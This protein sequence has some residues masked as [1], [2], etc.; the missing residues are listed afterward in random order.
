M[1]KVAVIYSKE[2]SRLDYTTRS[3]Q[4]RIRLHHYLK[5]NKMSFVES[6][7]FLQIELVVLI[8]IEG[9]QKWKNKL[10]SFDLHYFIYHISYVLRTEICSVY[11]I[12]IFQ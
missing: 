8:S 4:W 11:F 9:A 10:P 2:V 5:F 7:S 6:G 12:T 1:G 3:Y